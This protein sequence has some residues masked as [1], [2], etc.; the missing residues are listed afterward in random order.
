MGIGNEI[1][2]ERLKQ[3]YTSGEFVSKY[4][5]NWEKYFKLEN[6]FDVD[7]SLIELVAKYLQVPLSELVLRSEGC[8]IKK[9]YSAELN[10]K[11]TVKKIVNSDTWKDI[12]F[13]EKTF[14]GKIDVEFKNNLLQYL[15]IGINVYFDDTVRIGHF[16][17]TAF[18]SSDDEILMSNQVEI[19]KE[20][21]RRIIN[22]TK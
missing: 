11:E 3:G 8:L 6:G 22:K 4:S 12:M 5:L 20:L 21:K 15:V 13:K 9:V 2:K 17:M 19:Y 18:N 1:R 10:I 16:D 7:F 14:S